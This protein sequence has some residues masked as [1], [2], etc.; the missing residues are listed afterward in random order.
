VWKEKEFP[1][2]LMKE[3]PERIR[4]MELP[5]H[6]NKEFPGLTIKILELP[7]LFIKKD[8]L[9]ELLIT[10]KQLPGLAHHK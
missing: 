10:A 8:N 3:L 9:T 6:L 1:G 4:V 2:L 7:G 5:G